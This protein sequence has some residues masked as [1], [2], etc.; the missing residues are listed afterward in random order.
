MNPNDNSNLSRRRENDPLTHNAS[1]L[2]RTASQRRS[3]I[4]PS[5]PQSLSE[6]P[7][8]SNSNTPITPGS[9]NETSSKIRL[10]QT[11]IAQEK[12]GVIRFIGDTKFAA[13][14]WVGVELSDSTGKN[15]GS[16]Q[17]VRYFDVPKN[18]GLFVRPSQ[19]KLDLNSTPSNPDASVSSSKLQPSRISSALGKHP[20]SKPLN[21]ARRISTSISRSPSS[22]ISSPTPSNVGRI[23]RNSIVKGSITSTSTAVTPSTRTIN[24]HNPSPLIATT[25]SPV[26]VTPFHSTA[27]SRASSQPDITPS[28]NTTRS[29]SS[30]ATTELND[31]ENHHKSQIIPD[32]ENIQKSYS[33]EKKTPGRPALTMNESFMYEDVNNSNK[34][35]QLVPLSLYEE[36]KAKLKFL[37]QKRTDERSLILEAEE[38]KSNYNQT[39][40]TQERLVSKIQ[41]LNADNLQIKAEFKKTQDQLQ[42]LELTLDEERSTLEMVAI[43]KEMAEEQAECFKQDVSIYKEKLEELNDRLKLYEGTEALDSNE[44]S[45]LDFAQVRAKNVRLTEALRLLRDEKEYEIDDLKKKIRELEKSSSSLKQA[46]FSI[47]KQNQQIDQLQSIIEELKQRLEDS[48]DSEE[49]VIEL[50][51]RNSRLSD[52]VGDL[53]S[54]VE[55]WQSM[56][57]VSEEMYE[58]HVEEVKQLNSEINKLEWQIRESENTITSL[59]AT[60]EEN[61]AIIGRFRDAVAQLQKEQHKAA[62]REQEIQQK[63]ESTGEATK[64]LEKLA[65]NAGRAMQAVTSRGIELELKKVEA[66]QALYQIKIISSYLPETIIKSEMDSISLLITLRKI[67]FKADLICKQL[68]QP[69]NDDEPVNLEFYSTAVSRRLLAISARKSEILTRLLETSSEEDFSKYGYLLQDSISLDKRLNEVI[70]LAQ[71]NEMQYNLTLEIAKAAFSTI[72]KIE[73]RIPTSKND[74][75]LLKKLNCSTFE[76]GYCIDE[77]Q[78]FLLY[79]HQKC[80][81]EAFDVVNIIDNIKSLKMEL[82]RLQLKL[83]SIEKANQTFKPDINIEF[84]KSID[85]IHTLMNFCDSIKQS[86]SESFTTDDSDSS[87]NLITIEIFNEVIAHANSKIFKNESTK[88]LEQFG[89]F[90]L[91]INNLKSYSEDLLEIANDTNNITIS[92][93]ETTPWEAKAHRVSYEAKEE[94]TSNDIIASLKN[95][96]IEK[97]KTIKLKEIKL[98]EMKAHTSIL[99]NRCSQLKESKE[100]SERYKKELDES[101]QTISSLQNLVKTLNEDIDSSKEETRRLSKALAAAEQQPSRSRSIRNEISSDQNQS[102]LPGFTVSSAND[103]DSTS[104]NDAI[105]VA[106][107]EKSLLMQLSTCRSSLRLEKL[108]KFHLKSVMLNSQ[109]KSLAPIQSSNF[110]KY[111]SESSKSEMNSNKRDYSQLIGKDISEARKVIKDALLLAAAPKLVSIRKG[112]RTGETVNNTDIN[113][114]NTF[115]SSLS[116]M[117]P[118]NSHWKSQAV[119]QAMARR[120]IDISL[121]LH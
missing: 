62:E 89:P 20:I 120:A 83:Q 95:E 106:E 37:E 103:S 24:P 77:I 72:L 80:D 79:L 41:S 56:Y 11:V 63:F 40:R 116:L 100:S 58:G 110:S 88:S 23:S 108:E 43:E 109:A 76:V 1:N 8:S 3:T 15:D 47:E 90:L 111:L 68:E 12:Q 48:E 102:D 13:G 61:S 113:N 112:L 55:H 93:P 45:T 114:N 33:L 9:V 65:Y 10:G 7:T 104:R 26:P 74:T 105:P 17:G 86:I 57:E 81:P 70:I 64:N 27:L 50:S 94:Q 96:I 35:T 82:V 59:N 4:I 34:E 87:Q 52:K 25:S 118:N 49:L 46:S 39:K 28:L 107:S 92:P 66:S 44:S 101:L 29:T 16:V 2:A 73:E 19:L 99:D 18:H 30:I 98:E 21:D 71:K 32:P 6:R 22:R 84:V 67:E 31:I 14:T 38:I 54:Q 119:E 69:K 36:L 75:L 60:I 53:E 42:N 5:K 97:S 51:E 115:T 91:Y 117:N 85:Q 121:K 78:C